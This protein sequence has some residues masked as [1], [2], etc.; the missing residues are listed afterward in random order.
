MCICSGQGRHPL[1]SEAADSLELELQVTV[2]CLRWV[3]RANMA[4]P[5]KQQV[6]STAE[7]SLQCHRSVILL[8]RIPVSIR[9]DTRMWN[10]GMPERHPLFL[11]IWY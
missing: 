9:G 4:S 6:L 7:P 3:P 1:R 11:F 8:A 2:S 5:R 10:Q